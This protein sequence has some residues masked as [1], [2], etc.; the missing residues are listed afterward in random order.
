MI[1][2]AVPQHV[3]LSC[4]TSGVSVG[5][6]SVYFGRKPPVGVRPVR[7]AKVLTE[8]AWVVLWGFPS[9]AL[10]GSCGLSVSL[11]RAQQHLYA[12]ALQAGRSPAVVILSDAPF[13]GTPV[14]LLTLGAGIAAPSSGRTHC[15]IL[16]QENL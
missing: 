16:E 7:A 11:R 13:L 5:E 12:Q 8:P 9:S 4:A 6:A 2:K 3:G 10:P 15:V 14:I 1:F